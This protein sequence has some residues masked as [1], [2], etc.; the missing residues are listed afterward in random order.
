MIRYPERHEKGRVYHGL[1]EGT[2][3]PCYI[4][5]SVLVRAR[6]D[7]RTGAIVFYGGT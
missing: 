7:R 4:Y 5:G 1:F 2:K 6:R 3:Q